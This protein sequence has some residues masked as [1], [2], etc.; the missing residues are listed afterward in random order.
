MAAQR[1]TAELYTGVWQD[2]GTPERLKA[3]NAE[4]P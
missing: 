1:C 4:E 2:I 3:I